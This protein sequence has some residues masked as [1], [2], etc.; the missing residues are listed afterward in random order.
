MMDLESHLLTQLS[1]EVRD[2]VVQW[3]GL[4][5]KRMDQLMSLFFS[6]HNKLSQRAAWAV[7]EIARYKPKMVSPYAVRMYK[8]LNDPIHDA[9]RR[10]TLRAFQTIDIPEHIES[11]LFELCF[12]YLN[13]TRKPIAIRV[14][15]MDILTSIALRYPYLKPEVIDLINIHLEE[16]TGGYKSAARRNLMKLNKQV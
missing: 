12:S 5:K 2:Q 8:N 15:S 3:V 4:D 16:S 14:F 13:D 6:R 9:V 1:K 7:G 10:C 11:P